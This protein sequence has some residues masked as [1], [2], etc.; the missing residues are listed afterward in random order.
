MDLG[1]CILTVIFMRRHVLLQNMKIICIYYSYKDKV[2][3]RLLY[4]CVQ[5]FSG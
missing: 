3:F 4:K 1:S 5:G 2:L